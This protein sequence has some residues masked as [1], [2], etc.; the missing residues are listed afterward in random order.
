[1]PTNQETEM[2]SLQSELVFLQLWDV[3]VHSATFVRKSK[4]H[5]SCRVQSYAVFHIMSFCVESRTGYTDITLPDRIKQMTWQDTTCMQF[6]KVKLTDLEPQLGIS[7]KLQCRSMNCGK[8][9]SNLSLT[10]EWQKDFLT[11][12]NLSIN[13]NLY[14]LVTTRQ[15]FNTN[16]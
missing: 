4:K 11:F 10:A 9:C 14:L 5:L 3:A 13:H 1:M 6:V 7:D 8:D 12:A 15:S 2:V 16:I